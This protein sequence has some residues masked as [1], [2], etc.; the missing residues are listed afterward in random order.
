MITYWAGLRE[1]SVSVD[2]FKGG[3]S[4]KLFQ[5]KACDEHVRNFPL[6]ENIRALID[7]F[8]MLRS[9][10]LSEQKLKRINLLYKKHGNHVNS[11]VRYR[12]LIPYCSSARR[13]KKL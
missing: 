2:Q 13:L 12:V 1:M 10:N 9:A 4:G 3:G 8:R 7:I 6:T 11:N 5:H